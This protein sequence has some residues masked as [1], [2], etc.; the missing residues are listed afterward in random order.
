MRV[1]IALAGLI[2][3]SLLSGQ[4]TVKRPR[5]LGVAHVAVYVKDLDKTR[6]FYEGFLGVG[7]PFTLHQKGGS[8]VRIPFVNVNAYQYL[9]IFNEADR[10]EAQLNY[11]SLY[12]DNADRMRD[13][14]ASNGAKINGKRRQGRGA[15]GSDREQE[16]QRPLTGHLVEMVEYPPDSWTAREAGKFMPQ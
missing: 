15:Q 6:Q 2:L 16:F 1:R 3:A 12:T 11:I 14:V 4:E 8:G 9:E 10:G 7:E 5:I 13:Y